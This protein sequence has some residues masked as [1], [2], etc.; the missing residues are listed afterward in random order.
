MNLF[1]W[2]DSYDWRNAFEVCGVSIHNVNEV[3]L[4]DEGENDGRPW[5]A[6]VGWKG[7]EGKYAVIRAGCDYTGWDCRASGT[8]E[9]YNSL[10]ESVSVLTLTEEERGRFGMS[11]D[12][13]NKFQFIQLE[14]NS[15]WM[16]CYTNKSK[17]YTLLETENNPQLGIPL[18]V[19]ASQPKLFQTRELA[20]KEANVYP[21]W[22]K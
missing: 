18:F 7:P 6:V 19:Q 3:I 14:F 1:E 11:I 2:K 5:I 4:S 15:Q 13:G 21:H 10:E 16:V 12:T 22:P 17:T 8:I 9:F 20:E